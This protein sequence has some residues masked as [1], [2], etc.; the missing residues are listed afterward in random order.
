MTCC[1]VQAIVCIAQ[2]DPDTVW[3]VLHCILG[4]HQLHSRFNPD[5]VVFPDASRLLPTQGSLSLLGD[6][7]AVR[8]SVNALLHEVESI[9]ATWHSH[10]SDVE[11]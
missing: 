8:L 7:A 1:V 9:Q 6:V 3:L 2:D 5:A 4:G 10:C 11:K